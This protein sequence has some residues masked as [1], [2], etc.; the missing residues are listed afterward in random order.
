M[1]FKKSLTKI[2]KPDVVSAD[3]AS[4]QICICQ[5]RAV[6]SSTSLCRLVTG[7]IPVR[8][9]CELWQLLS[10]V[11]FQEKSAELAGTPQEARINHK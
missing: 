8:K 5:T 7:G 6:F 1:I 9:D 11:L 3:I 4:I 2:L 10:Y